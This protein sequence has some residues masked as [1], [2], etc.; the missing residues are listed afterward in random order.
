MNRFHKAKP[1]LAMGLIFVS[2]ANSQIILT[3][4]YEF[5][6]QTKNTGG[7]TVY[8][9]MV[10]NADPHW[11]EYKNVVTGTDYITFHIPGD[12]NTCPELDSIDY[13][14]KFDR[15]GITEEPSIGYLRYIIKVTNPGKSAWFVLEAQGQLFQGDKYFTYDWADDTFYMG[16]SC[17]SYGTIPVSNGSTI[18]THVD[19]GDGNLAFQP[20][21]PT[22]LVGSEVNNHPRLTWSPSLPSFSAIKYTVW[23]SISGG[24]R[25]GRNQVEQKRAFAIME[26]T[27]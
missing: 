26:L 11:N 15:G 25:L 9:E 14:Y 23:H 2:F 18:V 17:G 8:F 21:D 1:L 4:D 12:L 22:N 7:N 24:A 10:N 20:T 16:G 27:V 5:F 3:T 13:D 6:F 19:D